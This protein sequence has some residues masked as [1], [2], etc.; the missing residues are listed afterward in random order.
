MKVLSLAD[1]KSCG[2]MALKELGVD[3]EYYAVEIDPKKR[4]LSD[5]NFPEII[6][7]ADDFYQ[8]DKRWID[9]HGPFDLILAGT[10]CKNVSNAGKRDGGMS[11]KDLK[12]AI[13]IRD[14]VLAQNPKAHWF[15][16]NV[17]S[18]K[19]DMRDLYDD[20]VG[21][22]FTLMDSGLVSA[23]ARLRYYWSNFPLKTP[24]DR[25]IT[26]R[27][28][29]GQDW[30]G[31]AWSKSSRYKDIETGRVYSEPGPNR[32]KYIEQRQRTDGKANT[33]LTSKGCQGQST[34]N[35]AIRILS[36]GKIEQRHLTVREC[37]R[38]QT[39]PEY[40][41]FSCVSDADAYY[42]IGDGWTVEMI[43]ELLREVVE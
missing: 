4:K 18:M 35:W 8:I 17:A 31:L 11:V 37:A 25:G 39:I 12:Q 7:K 27:E 30:I 16:E 19:N 41:D 36:K 40:F 34:A 22:K 2:L 6:R 38:L 14:M 20:L 32:I 23:Q 42:A 21:C 10:S 3:C 43:K 9:K 26:F 15:F 5:H 33:L 28:I 13:K 24:Q 1:G 29:L